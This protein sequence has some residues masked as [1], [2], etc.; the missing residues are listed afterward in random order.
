MV[1]LSHWRAA[2]EALLGRLLGG[3]PVHDSGSGG[4]RWRSDREVPPSWDVVTDEEHRPAAAGH[5]LDAARVALR[6]E[7]RVT[8][9]EHFVEQQDF[10]IEVRQSDC[11]GESRT[12]IPD[13]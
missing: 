10:R 5:F 9:S 3:T 12:C 8:H 4:G 6:L 2:Q 13:E 7:G 1:L 11:E